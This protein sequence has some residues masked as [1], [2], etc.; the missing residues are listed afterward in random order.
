[1]LQCTR[2]GEEEEFPRIGNGHVTR[3]GEATAEKSP[4]LPPIYPHPLNEEHSSKSSSIEFLPRNRASRPV[5]S[6]GKFVPPVTRRVC[7]RK[8]TPNRVF[9]QKSSSQSLCLLP[10]SLHFSRAN[11][12]R[13]EKGSPRGKPIP[14][15]PNPPPTLPSSPLIPSVEID[16]TV[17]PLSRTS[18][19]LVSSRGVM[20][21]NPEGEREREG[22]E[23]S[24]K[25]PRRKEKRERKRV[26]TGYI[27]GG[28]LDF[29]FADNSPR[30]HARGE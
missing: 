18:S 16:L 22:K 26:S 8:C 20:N 6:P 9:F 5:R 2:K 7:A 15:E 24:E 21:R 1:M 23:K 14:L 17:S 3:I 29:R 13:R 4:R 30:L 11:E 27:G 10:I 12:P 19:S 28:E 25:Y